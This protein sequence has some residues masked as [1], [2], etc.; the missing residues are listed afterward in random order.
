[1]NNYVGIVKSV[2]RRHVRER[3]HTCDTGKGCTHESVWVYERDCY[4]LLW[5]C[6][7]DMMV[8]GL[9]GGGCAA[10]YQSTWQTRINREPW[11]RRI[12][13][14][15]LTHKGSSLPAV[16]TAGTSRDFH[17]QQGWRF[18][19]GWSRYEGAITLGLVPDVL[20]AFTNTLYVWGQF[21]QKFN[22]P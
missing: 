3:I 16:R 12:L 7:I 8:G 17:R 1:M 20:F 19:Q 22:P 11:S 13:S 21:D 15:H 18:Q 5:E 2:T 14:G 4:V 10:S 6:L 9:A